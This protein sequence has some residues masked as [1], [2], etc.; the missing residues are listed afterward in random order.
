MILRIAHYPQVLC[1]AF[2]VDVATIDEALKIINV[3]A[4]YDLFQ[5]HNKIKPNY[6]NMCV[7]EYYDEEEH[8]WLEWNDEEGYTIDKYDLVNGKASLESIY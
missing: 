3:L 2:Y 7:L 1:E 6:A 4:N 8:D 5:Y